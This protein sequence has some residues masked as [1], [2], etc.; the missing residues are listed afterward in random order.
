MNILKIVAAVIVGIL[1]LITNIRVEIG[2]ASS[3]ERALDGFIGIAVLI[4][5]VL[6]VFSVL[7]K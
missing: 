6:Y 7:K 4:S 1:L 2:A 3:F 5:L